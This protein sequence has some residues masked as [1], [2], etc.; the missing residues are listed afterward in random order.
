ME[1]YQDVSAN[2]S[3]LGIAAGVIALAALGWGVW[4]WRATR[5]R[6]EAVEAAQANAESQIGEQQAQVAGLQD[7]LST[8]QQAQ[9]RE[10]IAL[11]LLRTYQDWLLQAAQDLQS[12]LFNILR[13]HLLRNFYFDGSFSEKEYSVENTLYVIAEY[14]CWV[15][16]IRREVQFLGVE[17]N[18]Q[19][20]QMMNCV[21]SVA[22]TFLTSSLPRTFRVFRGEQ[23]AIGEIMMTAPDP[24]SA[25]REP[26]GYATFLRMR[27]D[28]EF[29]RWFRQ[30]RM[31]I[32][33]LANGGGSGERLVRLQ[34]SLVD[35]ID[36]LD[37]DYRRVPQN[38]RGKLQMSE[39]SLP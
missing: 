28:E 35:L 30:L 9:S 21:G 19:P 11:D 22:E 10:H 2:L 39:V 1:W 13:L 6:L 37:P 17:E 16:I 4:W 27:K 15:E 24:G 14:L 5:R 38:V 36:C 18:Q 12:K 23:R 26:I 34:N 29:S 8:Q 33:D 3:W 20:G 7:E 32:D 25:R 31:D